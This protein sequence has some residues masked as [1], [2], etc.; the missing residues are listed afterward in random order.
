MRLFK[1]KRLRR[2]QPQA[3]ARLTAAQVTYGGYA[4]TCPNCGHMFSCGHVANRIECLG[5]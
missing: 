4:E 1:F 3:R 5:A 2:S